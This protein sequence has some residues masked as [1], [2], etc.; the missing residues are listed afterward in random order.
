MEAGDFDAV[1]IPGGFEEHGFF[2]EAYAE[3]VLQ[4]LRDFNDANKPVA[5]ICVGALPLGKSG[6]LKGKKATTYQLLGG[7]RRRQLAEFGAEVV[8]DPIVVEGNTITSTS[9]ATAIEVALTLVA[10]LTTAENAE[11]IRRLMGFRSESSAD[12]R[13]A[14]ETHPAGSSP[15]HGPP[16]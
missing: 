12:L 1:A 5:S 2:E 3:V 15:P 13:E 4:K 7:R 6:I 8:D 16:T 11:R 9:P 14:S 10:R